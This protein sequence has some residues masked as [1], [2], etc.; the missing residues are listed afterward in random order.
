MNNILCVFYIDD[1]K[2][3]SILDDAVSSFKK[4]HDGLVDIYTAKNYQNGLSEIGNKYGGIGKY[5]MAW[6]L[7]DEEKYDKCIILGA[8]TITCARLDEFLDND[9][10]DMLLTLDYKERIVINNDTGDS[11]SGLNA[12]IICFNNKEALEKL[13][14]FTP[15][16]TL[17]EEKTCEQGALNEVVS[18]GDFS[19]LVVD[20]EDSD[21]YY[22]VRSKGKDLELPVWPKKEWLQGWTVNDGKLYTPDDRQIKIFH[23][24]SS[25]GT[26]TL[27]EI[28]SILEEK[29]TS[30]FNNETL[31]FFS[32]VTG[33][34]ELYQ[35]R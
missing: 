13:L 8:D 28:N 4:F 1:V 30:R 7:W 12:D 11:F 14:Y 24:C 33:N 31:Q 27:E 26:R 29:Y 9:D 10:Y 3:E 20:D 17:G 25:F 23:Y 16:F 19:Y 21:V 18:I 15:Y 5:E 6:R 35:Q 22:N 34:K 2:F 32:D